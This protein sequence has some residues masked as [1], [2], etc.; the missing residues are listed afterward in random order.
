MPTYRYG[1]CKKGG[2]ELL[3]LA[4]E[5]IQGALAPDVAFTLVEDSSSAWIVLNENHAEKIRLRRGNTAD[6]NEYWPVNPF[7]PDE[8]E[9]VKVELKIVR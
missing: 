9:V 5:M 7:D 8:L 1:L 6:S 2:D 3:G 4:S